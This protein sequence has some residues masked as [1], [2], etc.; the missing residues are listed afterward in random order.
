MESLYIVDESMMSVIPGVFSELK[1]TISQISKE[2]KLEIADI[3]EALKDRNIYRLLISVGPRMVMKAL[4]AFSDLISNTLK[5]AFKEIHDSPLFKGVQKN[6]QHITAILD[7]HPILRKVS[8]IALAGFLIYLWLNTSFIGSFDFDFDVSDIVEA[9]KGQY[10]VED[11]LGSPD[12]VE[13]M[14]L[15]TTGAII[16]LSVDWLEKGIYNVILAIVYTFFKR[17]KDSIAPLLKIK[18]VLA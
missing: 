3:I 16:G 13:Y 7:K 8:G 17:N 1:S 15:F 10:T 11:F 12:L 5:R 18:M 6:T 2:F 14:F 9:A 4:I